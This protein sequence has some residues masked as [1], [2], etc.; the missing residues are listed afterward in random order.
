MGT[1]VACKVYYSRH[2]IPKGSASV[3]VL[4]SLHLLQPGRQPCRALS[5]QQDVNQKEAENI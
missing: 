2:S 5:G 4:L 3:A 1:A